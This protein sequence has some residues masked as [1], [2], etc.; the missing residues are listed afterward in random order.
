MGS[1]GGAPEMNAAEPSGRASNGVYKL[2]TDM[3]LPL[4]DF[5]R[6]LLPIPF[7][8]TTFEE[9]T[10]DNYYKAFLTEYLDLVETDA[11][12]FCA[13]QNTGEAVALRKCFRI[14]GI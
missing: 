14:L 7:I 2:Q 5:E 11:G 8:K 12:I 4:M 6:Q 3:L 9:N 1:G 10:N 13:V